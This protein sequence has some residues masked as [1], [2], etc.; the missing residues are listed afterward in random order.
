MFRFLGVVI[1]G[2]LVI[3]GASRLDTWAGVAATVLVLTGVAW[4]L[5]S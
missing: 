2:A 1:V 4:W 5:R 3:A